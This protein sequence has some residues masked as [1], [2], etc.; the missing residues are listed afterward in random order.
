MKCS[1]AFFP[2]AYKPNKNYKPEPFIIAKN[3]H[4]QVTVNTPYA[5]NGFDYTVFMAVLS[6]CKKQS[7]TADYVNTFCVS[8]PEIAKQLGQKD[9]GTFR[10]RL[11]KS[12]SALAAA[13]IK[14]KVLVYENKL[15]TDT[16]FVINYQITQL[17]TQHNLRVKL[18]ELF[19]T[20]LFQASRNYC[21][22][23]LNVEKQLNKIQRY[24]YG[25]II[26]SVAIGKFPKT[27][28]INDVLQ[29]MYCFVG[30]DPNH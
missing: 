14:Y 25:L 29:S 18:N 30:T 9:G 21:I 19:V 7:I 2:F 15:V 17:K 23:D 16:G 22:Y 5:L 1:N 20:M 10:I 26:N 13:S 24:L 6:Q 8:M 11:T 28:K 27:F 4:N 3:E 12:L